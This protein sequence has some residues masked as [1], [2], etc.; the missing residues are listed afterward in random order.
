MEYFKRLTRFSAFLL[1]IGVSFVVGQLIPAFYDWTGSDQSRP[2][3]LTFQTAAGLL[4]CGIIACLALP[5][6]RI[7]YD[8]P[9]TNRVGRVQFNIRTI[10]VIT[11]VVAVF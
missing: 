9:A 8:L 7:E 4:L 5:W 11:A 1:V 3:P 10:L 2:S 6:L